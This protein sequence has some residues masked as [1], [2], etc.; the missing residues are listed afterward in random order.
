MVSTTLTVL[1][2]ACLTSHLLIHSGVNADMA[3]YWSDYA[4]EK[5]QS[6]TSHETLCDNLAQAVETLITS[7]FYIGTEGN[8]LSVSLSSPRKIEGEQLIEELVKKVIREKIK[9]E[10]K[11][12]KE[13]QKSLE[14][15]VG[16]I[17]NHPDTFQTETQQVT[18]LHTEQTI[19][20]ESQS[21]GIRMED[22]PQLDMD[23]EVL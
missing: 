13:V 18:D 19:N 11:V 7:S 15:W 9:K 2:L 22:V 20:S 3:T 21:E 10:D 14:D 8:A 4:N 12:Y 5:C 23:E 1:V 16:K 6:K 17:I